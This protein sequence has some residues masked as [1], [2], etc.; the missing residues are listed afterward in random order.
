MF[1]YYLMIL[2]KKPVSIVT[3]QEG[4][5]RDLIHFD[6]NLSGIP[7]RFI[8]SAGIRETSCKIEAL[9]VELAKKT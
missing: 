2:A 3:E 6:A 1:I 7:I 8:D 4:T 5:T 9:G